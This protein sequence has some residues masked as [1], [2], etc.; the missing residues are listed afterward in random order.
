MPLR[1]VMLGDIVG[2]AG[3][4]AVAQQLPQIRDQ[5]QP[6]LILANAENVANGSGITPE[7]YKKLCDLGIQGLTLGDHVYKKAQ[8]IPTLKQ[9]QNL[10]RPANLPAQAIGKTW[11][12]L[13]AGQGER[14]RPVYVF[15]VLGR[16][17]MNLNADDP[18]AAAESII[19]T[20][21]RHDNSTHNTTD[22]PIIIVEVHAEATSEKQ[23]IGW[24]LNG[25]VSA[26]LGT[27]TH[28]PTADARILD[29]GTAYI[30]DLGM[31]GPQESVLGR[32]IDR[33]LTYMT[34]AMPAPFDVAEGDPRACGVLI[35]ISDH[36]SR[37][38][39]IERIELK[40]DVNAPPF[41]AG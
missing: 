9:A 2:R 34:T 26:V 6:D 23:A 35:E 16:I 25:R 19:H 32:K 27:H 17:F 38:T 21:T 10:I 8:I 24:H 1:I 29:Q 37:A 40:A 20:I 7:F 31:C 41:V 3:R 5:Y 4:L 14:T 30:T 28:V 15:T 11:M 33:V 13:D 22:Q 36:S 12:C 18:F 39:H